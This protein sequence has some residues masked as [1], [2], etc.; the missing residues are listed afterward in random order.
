MQLSPAQWDVVRRIAAEQARG[1]IKDNPTTSEMVNLVSEARAMGFSVSELREIRSIADSTARKQIRQQRVEQLAS[2]QVEVS[3]LRSELTTMQ[4]AMT[5][6]ILEVQKL[7]NQYTLT[8]DPNG[9]VTGVNIKNQCN[10]F[11]TRTSNYGGFPYR[12]NPN[13]SPRPSSRQ[14]PG[15]KDG[16]RCWNDNKELFIF[17]RGQ[18]R[19]RSELEAYA[20][21]AKYL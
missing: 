5:N 13:P 20:S 17:F 2:L 16:D 9:C 3:N 21:A 14:T 4:A 15:A 6:A 11:E 8:L 1:V 7:K 19:R 10:V 12:A 18:W